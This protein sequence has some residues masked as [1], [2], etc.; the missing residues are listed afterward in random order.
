MYAILPMTTNILAG[1][2]SIDPDILQAAYGMGM[3]QKQV[4]RKVELPLV[5]PFLFSGFSTALVQ[6]V[7]NTILAG[8]VGGGGIG[9][10][11]FLGLAQSAPDFVILGA[12]LVVSVALVLKLILANLQLLI[13]RLNPVEVQHD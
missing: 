5:F 8:L 12:L 3:T 13:K 10:I 1:Y 2:N 11:L 9:A 7:G 6:T 4:H